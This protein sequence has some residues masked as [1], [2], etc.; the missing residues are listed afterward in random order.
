MSKRKRRLRRLW[1]T[2]CVK[3]IEP[4]SQYLV[5]V[6]SGRKVV[7]TFAARCVSIDHRGY[8]LFDNDVIVHNASAV[9]C[10][11]IDESRREVS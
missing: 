4:D 2:L 10:V 7:V 3:D 9:C 8:V 5:S 1:R 6:L 11:L